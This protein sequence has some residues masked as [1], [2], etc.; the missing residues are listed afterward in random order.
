MACSPK[1]C[2]DLLKCRSDI[3]RAACLLAHCSVDPLPRCALSNRTQSDGKARLVLRAADN[4][5]WLSSVMRPR[6]HGVLWEYWCFGWSQHLAVLSQ[7][8]WRRSAR[9]WARCR[10]VSTC[11]RTEGVTAADAAESRPEAAVWVGWNLLGI[12]AWWGAD[13]VVGRCACRATRRAR[14]S[15]RPGSKRAASG[16]MGLQRGA[17]VA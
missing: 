13:G 9:S 8:V 17:R 10:L 4:R 7:A 14:N 6:F 16:A 12:A 1:R 2:L 5:V 11:P 15:R 3:S